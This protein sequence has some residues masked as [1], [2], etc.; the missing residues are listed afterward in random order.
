[1][2]GRRLPFRN[3]EEKAAL[4]VLDLSSP[5]ALPIAPVSTTATVSGVTVRV[6][7]RTGRLRPPTTQQKRALATAFRQQFSQPSPQA[8]YSYGSGMLSLVVGQSQLNF[9]VAHVTSKGELE[10]SCLTGVEEAATLL[11]E[12]SPLLLANSVPKEE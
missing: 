7:P 6:D 5:T 8:A 11:E 12:S 1:M 9:S 10:V 2:S 4:H 3:D